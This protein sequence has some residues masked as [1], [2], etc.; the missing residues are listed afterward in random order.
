MVKRLVLALPLA[1]VGAAWFLYLSLPWPVP[2]RWRE[3]T[4]T[5]FMEHRLAEA[6]ARGEALEIEFQW[7]PLERI[8]PHL[9]RAAIV[10]ED[11]R[12]RDHRGIDWAA[13]REEVRY[14]GDTIFDWTDPD[15]LRALADAVRYY[16]EHRDEIRGRSTITQQLA[17]NL[18]FSPERSLLRKVAEF[19]VARRL[20]RF[21]TKDR[22]LEL[23]LN[24]AEWGPGIFGAEAAAR[25]YFGRSAAEL[26]RDQAAALAATLPH[27]L[28]SNPKY[29]PGRMTWRKRMILERMGGTAESTTDPSA[30]P[31]PEVK[32][33][34][35]EPVLPLPKP[36]AD[37]G[38]APISPR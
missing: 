9:R 2:L 23:Y 38:A 36:P 27:P 24:T 6:T 33:P 22:I 18:Y 10:A 28:T 8:S 35:A 13:L 5:A 3:P 1:A 7:V 16:L 21:L 26:T 37:T 12:F 29:R 34:L 15:D 19:E 14:G 25:H 17:K 31:L 20:E 4:R 11:A 30:A 32:I